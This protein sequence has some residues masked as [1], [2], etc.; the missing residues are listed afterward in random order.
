MRQVPVCSSAEYMTKTTKRAF[1]KLSSGCSNG[2]LTLFL[3][4]SQANSK[5]NI[6]SDI[7]LVIP[8]ISETPLRDVRSNLKAQLGFE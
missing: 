4:F 6:N 3:I 5:P 7:Y 1:R 2:G 8:L